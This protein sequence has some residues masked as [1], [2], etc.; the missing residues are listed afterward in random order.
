MRKEKSW[1]R[2]E[3]DKRNRAMKG[4]VV[5]NATGNSDLGEFIEEVAKRPRISKHNAL[6]VWE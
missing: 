1:R 4:K 6:K 2:S 5:A 3:K